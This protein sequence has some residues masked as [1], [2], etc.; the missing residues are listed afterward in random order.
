MHTLARAGACGAAL[1]AAMIPA[2]NCEIPRA[3]A[4]SSTVVVL[5]SD[6][7]RCDFSLVSTDPG[8]PRTGL[9]TGTAIIR[10]SGSTASAEVHLS[11]G[12]DPGTHFDVGLI[13]VPRPAAATCGPGDPGTV[14][15]RL[16]LDG[17]GNGTVTVTE[18]IGPGTTGVWVIV[19]R[20]NPHSQNPAEFYTSEFVAPV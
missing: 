12:P 5:D 11:D 2:I 6:L 1:T 18:G 20:G 4:E 17:A 14:F 7:R 3:A 10:R 13:Q 16:D 9:G 19:E 15:G 8:V